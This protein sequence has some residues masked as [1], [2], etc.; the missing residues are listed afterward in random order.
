M[1][2]VKLFVLRILFFVC[3]LGWT[4]A[5]AGDIKLGTI[6]N[7][8]GDM[9]ISSEEPQE[10]A[11][12]IEFI[13]DSCYG[14]GINTVA[15]SIGAGSEILLYPTE[16]GNNWGWR[17]TSYDDDPRWKARINR[18]RK[19][20]EKKFD[21]VMV[22]A[23]QTRKLGMNFFPSIRINDSHFIFNPQEYPLTGKFWLDNPDCRIG[24]TGSS[25]SAKAK[26]YE[27]LLDYSKQKVRDYRL[28]MISEVIDRY[29]DYMAG[30][31]LDFTRS[32][33]LFPPEI[34]EQSGYLVTDMLKQIRN[35]LDEANN[36]EDKLIIARVPTNLDS[37]KKLG[38]EIDEWIKLGLINVIVPAQL[39]TTAFEMPVD[40][41][42]ELA[43]P[44]GCKVYANVYPRV[45]WEFPYT[46]DAESY[47]V[48]PDRMI[49]P[50]L[51]R[52]AYSNYW[53]MGADGIYLFNFKTPPTGGDE[54][55][56]IL[57]DSAAEH[58]LEYTDKVY[59]VTKA[60]YL[61]YENTYTYVKSIP[62]VIES[63][64]SRSFSIYMTENIKNQI[65]PLKVDQ[66]GF[67]IG[68]DKVVSS[69]IIDLWFNDVQLKNPKL[70]KT[71][72][73]KD[74]T[75]LNPKAAA[76]FL[77]YSIDDLNIIKDGENS[78]VVKT[79]ELP[80][81]LYITDINVGM[82]YDNDMI[83]ILIN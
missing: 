34:A 42:C 13:I 36:G 65:E 24:A 56:R 3:M 66:A 27:N 54:Y 58:C 2:G 48:A 21:A 38:Y 50:Q 71:N 5:I 15:Y 79:K 63:H 7:D 83:K 45:G 35:K 60:Y 80:A 78:V 25:P 67:R 46:F 64:S 31:E 53:D 22:A 40:E 29:N 52:A 8:D 81:A 28:S 72:P 19:L 41:F 39:M 59:A 11:K 75:R 1:L 62:T 44:Y 76:C 43:K 18:G 47:D 37:C 55:Y 4:V 26:Q 6:W 20:A 32:F 33:F 16:V 17:S 23:L 70:V 51:A 10:A 73:P 77:Q 61:D 82:F 30:I 74:I 57:R 14:T 9:A 69:D 68:F 12:I 49:T